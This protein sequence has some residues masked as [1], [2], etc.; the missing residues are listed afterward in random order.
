MKGK[1]VFTFFGLKLRG[2]FILV[3]MKDLEKIGS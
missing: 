3:K 2:E 1:L